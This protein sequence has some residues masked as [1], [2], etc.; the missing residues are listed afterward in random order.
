MFGDV[1]AETLERLFWSRVKKTPSCWLWTGSMDVR[2]YPRLTVKRWISKA[3]RLAWELFRG[4]IPQGAA[5]RCTCKNR[6]CVNPDHHEVINGAP[7]R[8]VRDLTGQ[9]FGKLVAIELIGHSPVLWKCVCDCGRE[10]IIRG[11]NLSRLGGQK[12]CGCLAKNAI[13]RL[14]GNKQ[15]NHGLSRTTEYRIW[16]GMKGRCYNPNT[17]R[18]ISY[19]GRGITVCERWRNSFENFLQDMGLRPAGKT[20][21]R[22]DND[23]NYEPGNCRWATRKEQAG[24]QRLSA[25]FDWFDPSQTT[26]CYLLKPIRIAADT[27]SAA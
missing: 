2:G 6:N 26:V 24:H 18:F 5:I 14:S 8:P 9:R 1:K 27:V 16:I 15:T 23:G 21:D 3:Y 12:S 11:N 25:A 7:G 13:F 4:P 19:G 10:S 22:I 17:T 20:L